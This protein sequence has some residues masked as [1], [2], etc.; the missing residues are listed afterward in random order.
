MGMIYNEFHPFQLCTSSRDEPLTA[1]NLPELIHRMKKSDA[2][3][4]G[5]LNAVILLKNDNTQIVLTAIHE[6]TEITSFQSNDSITFQIIEGELIFTP[7]GN[8]C[9]WT[10]DI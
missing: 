4:N 3:T 9:P 6:G 1:L 2:W 10:R 8:L 7:A 5:E